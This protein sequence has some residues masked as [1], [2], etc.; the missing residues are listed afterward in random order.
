MAPQAAVT[1]PNH[2]PGDVKWWSAYWGQWLGHGARVRYE[3]SGSLFNT[4]DAPELTCTEDGWKPDPPCEDRFC[5]VADVQNADAVHHWIKRV[6]LDIS[7]TFMCRHDDRRQ[8]TLTCTRQGWSGTHLCP[9]ENTRPLEDPPTLPPRPPLCPK[10]KVKN[11]FAVQ[12][13]G[14]VAHFT[15]HHEFKLLSGASWGVAECTGGV[16][17]GLEP[18]IDRRVCSDVPEV[19][20]ADVKVTP[21]VETHED[22]ALVTCRD[23]SSGA[24]SHLVCR[25]GS[26]DSDGIPI[27]NICPTKAEPCGPPPE[28]KDA[29]ITTPYQNKYQWKSTVTY[30]CRD[31]FTLEG[32][33]QI[34][35]QFGKWESSDIKCTAFCFKPMEDPPT[36]TFFPDK[37]RYLQGDV[38]EYQC[39]TP[40]RK[41]GGSVTCDQGSWR[42][43]FNC[44]AKPCGPPEGTSNGYYQFLKDSETTVQYFCN[45]GFEMVNRVD[46]RTCLQGRWSNSVPVCEAT[47]CPLPTRDESMAVIN[48]PEAEGSVAPGHWL[49]FS[50]KH[51][52]KV[53]NGSADL[54]C[55]L[56][57]RWDNEFPT[58]ED[59]SCTVGRMDPRLRVSV[60]PTEHGAAYQQKLRFDCDAGSF[61]DGA[62]EIE[63]LPS[64]KWSKPVPTCSEPCKLTGVDDSVQLE[65]H[66]LDAPV[67]RGE[68][69]QFRCRIR[70][71]NLRGL[72]E[73]ECLH[74][75]KWSAPFP[76]SGAKNCL[77]LP[78]LTEGDMKDSLRPEYEHLQQVE[79]VCKQ[80]YVMQGGPMKT[81][82]NGEWQGDIKCLEPC[83]VDRDIM[84]QR[85]ITFRYIRD[86]KVYLTHDDVIEFMCIRGRMQ[87][88]ARQRCVEGHIDLPTCQ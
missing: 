38:L 15:C 51:P 63:C 41:T 82:V 2:R 69:V 24:I 4:D 20:N 14:E 9:V 75:S 36:M 29:I 31:K 76:T 48:L 88:D 56:N 28:V 42:Q 27:D 74:D 18:C 70:S 60:I 81:C 50:C 46:T 5:Y 85:H 6:Y 65:S 66:E 11:G 13:V 40:D 64:G 3:C 26:W 87:G 73:V 59:V 55:K 86:D 39:A 61:V 49:R 44:E 72:K 10:P 84:N 12:T 71:H 77:S 52:G 58:C 79:M 33:D 57:G 68:K 1:C 37:E 32:R 35:C 83:T 34:Q 78:T 67:R 54:T 45:E 22:V 47:T 62:E 7:V 23:G 19:P 53:L 21:G 43:P 80:F 30:R 25:N 16:W 8:F 17:V